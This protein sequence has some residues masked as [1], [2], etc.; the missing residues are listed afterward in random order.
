VRTVVF[1]DGSL[2]QSVVEMD[3]T[4]YVGA[5]KQC[6]DPGS[7]SAG[8]AV[9]HYEQTVELVTSSPA[10]TTWFSVTPG[11]PLGDYIVLLDYKYN[12]SSNSTSGQVDLVDGITILE[13]A[14]HGSPGAT[15]VTIREPGMMMT[16]APIAP[17]DTISVNISREGGNGVFTVYRADL[18]LVPL[19]T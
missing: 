14:I 11:V 8:G 17:A 4:P 1:C 9:F 10:P 12:I 5:V 2:N 15:S 13:Q 18:V 16:R 19:N 3:G 6:P 7:A